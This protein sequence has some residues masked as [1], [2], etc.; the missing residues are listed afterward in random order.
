MG[1]RESSS[2]SINEFERSIKGAVLLEGV[3]NDAFD[4]SRKDVSNSWVECIVSSWSCVAG[5]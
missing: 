3:L 2:S 4:L 5:F 1:I